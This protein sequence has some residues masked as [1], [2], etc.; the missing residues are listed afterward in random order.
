M[1]R[2]VALHRLVLAG[3]LIGSCLLF[4]ARVVCASD[5]L[6]SPQDVPGPPDKVFVTPL[7]DASLRVQ[8]LPPVRTKAEGSNGAP[9][10]GYKVEV[11]RRVNHI[12]TFTVS[13]SGPVLAGSYK[14]TFENARGI[15]V[16]ACIPWNA[17][18]VMFE[19]ALEELVNVDSVSVSRSAYG[20]AQFGYIYKVPL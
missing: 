6:V 8:F 9:V 11:A 10:L 14:L 15:G 13:A 18:E 16:T 3:V 17:T 4:A 20:A 19:T 5:L 1:R 7:D 2:D 12:Q